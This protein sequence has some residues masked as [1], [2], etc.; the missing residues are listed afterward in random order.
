MSKIKEELINAKFTNLQKNALSRIL[1]NS[2]NMY[3]NRYM[4]I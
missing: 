1:P 3:I 4:Y 2:V